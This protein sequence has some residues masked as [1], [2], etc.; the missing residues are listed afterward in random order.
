VEKGV[1]V[2]HLTHVAFAAI[3]VTA[4]DGVCFCSAL[5]CVGVCPFSEVFFDDIAGHAGEIEARNGC[6]TLLSIII[7]DE[8]NYAFGGIAIGSRVLVCTILYPF[9]QPILMGLE[10]CADQPDSAFFVDLHILVWRVAYRA[11]RS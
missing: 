1:A 6:G 10:W 4:L 5:C 7:E 11:H 9:W 8:N 2:E 3:A